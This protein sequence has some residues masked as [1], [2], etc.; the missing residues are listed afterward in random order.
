LILGYSK[1]S[2]NASEVKYDGTIDVEQLEDKKVFS[3]NL[4]SDPEKLDTKDQ[5][6]FKVNSNK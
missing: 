5:L 3:L 6:I 1:R 2:Y 4:N